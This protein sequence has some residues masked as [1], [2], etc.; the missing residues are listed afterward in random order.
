MEKTNTS[1]INNI[2]STVSN[3]GAT[4]ND[5]LSK[6]KLEEIE[7][8]KEL[9]SKYGEGSIDLTKGEFTSSN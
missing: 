1:I 8:G 3:I 2:G 7:V 9:Q 6:L 5:Q 4:V